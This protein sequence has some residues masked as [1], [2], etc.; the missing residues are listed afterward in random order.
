MISKHVDIAGAVV[1]WSAG[2]T[3][4][5]M[6]KARLAAIGY[7]DCS[8]PERTG[9]ACLKSALRDY[10]DERSDRRKGKDKLF[11]ARKKQKENGFEVL[12]VERGTDGNDYRMDFAAKLTVDGQ[13]VMTASGSCDIA[14]LRE[15]FWKHR[16]QV[17]SAAIGQLLVAVLNR[18]GGVCLR[19]SG[20]VYWIPGE[21]VRELE[22]IASVVEECAAEGETNAI[23]TITHEFNERSVRAVKDA[24][25]A[26]VT[27]AALELEEEIRVNKMGTEALIRRQL[28]AASLHAR[29][30]KYEALLGETLTTVHDVI[31]VA[32]EAAAAAIS[33]ADDADQ[34]A[35]IL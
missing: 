15:H 6:L 26:E 14:A 16:S 24:I 10:C 8:P 22:Q 20:G 33:V 2:P 7:E 23:Y 30:G 31:R 3:R 19:P 1:Y 9:A 11:Q 4:R 13:S 17:T 18:M 25:V 12:D 29:A 21:H 5:E 35:G 27:A 34:Y 32:Q 28:Q